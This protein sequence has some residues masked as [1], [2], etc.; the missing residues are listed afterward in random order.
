MNV[1]DA[2][3]ALVQT[4]AELPGS[5]RPEFQLGHWDGVTGG[6]DSWYVRFEGDIDGD[7]GGSWFFVMGQ[8]PQEVLLRAADE[9]WR[10]LPGGDPRAK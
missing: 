3:Q 2:L 9:A 4:A 6:A 7:D 5:F 8:T 1:D 10:R